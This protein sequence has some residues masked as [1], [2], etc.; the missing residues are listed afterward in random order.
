[1]ADLGLV[2]REINALPSAQRAIFLRIFQAVLKDIRFGHP[3]LAQPDPCVNI[4]G[5]F[6]TATTPAVPGTEFSIAHGFGRVPYLLIPVLPLDAVGATLVPLAVTR[7]ADDKRIYLSST[8]ASAF[9]CVAV[10]G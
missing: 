3:K 6:F 10:E 4:G 7:A 2:E 8:S 9:V 5:G 1:M